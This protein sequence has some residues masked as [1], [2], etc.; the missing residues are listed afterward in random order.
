[1]FISTFKHQRFYEKKEDIEQSFKR[2]INELKR[3]FPMNHHIK[4]LS[5]LANKEIK[6]EP[7]NEN[8]NIIS[9]VKKNEPSIDF[10]KLIDDTNTA[11]NNDNTDAIHEKVM[12]I[13]QKL[14]NI[15]KANDIETK[16]N[17]LKEQNSE[18]IKKIINEKPVGREIM[19]E[20][21]KAAATKAVA[22]NQ[23]AV[24]TNQPAVAA[25]AV[26]KEEEEE[27]EEEPGTAAE[28]AAAEKEMKELILNLNNLITGLESYKNDVAHIYVAERLKQSEIIK[29]GYKINDKDSNFMKILD[30]VIENLNK[31]DTSKI[32]SDDSKK[33]IDTIKN[34]KIARLKAIKL[35]NLKLSAEVKKDIRRAEIKLKQAKQKNEKLDSSH[36]KN[37]INDI[38]SNKKELERI[39]II[40]AINAADA[41]EQEAKN[42]LTQ[43][44]NDNDKADEEEAAAVMAAVREVAAV[45]KAVEREAAAR[46]A[47]EEEDEK[48]TEDEIR[49]KKEDEKEATA[50]ATKAE[51]LVSIMDAVSRNTEQ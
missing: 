37:D 6:K 36:T 33:D 25:V 19:T 22:T 1:V 10:K 41:E 21:E 49:K 46:R 2:Y 40:K 50:A 31:I 44:N 8:D 27:E 17:N 30:E 4:L 13:I 51:A 26:E 24:A 9:E 45:E 39:A 48:L 3:Q 16:I 32:D 12:D 5:D 35:K 42:R 15:K 18:L 47:E 43:L 14:E 20:A 23:P 29:D 11:L 7:L 38:D 28:L 34:V